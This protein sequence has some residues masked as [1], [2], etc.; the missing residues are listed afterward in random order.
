MRTMMMMVMMMLDD[1]FG[2]ARPWNCRGSG[3]GHVFEKS[4]KGCRICFLKDQSKECFR[5]G[6]DDADDDDDDADDDDD[7]HHHDHHQHHD[8]DDAD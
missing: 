1:G 7:D 2:S 6:P 8:H 5:K 4:P 3:S